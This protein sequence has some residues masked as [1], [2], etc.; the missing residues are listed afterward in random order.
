MT[1]DFPKPNASGTGPWVAWFGYDDGYTTISQPF[2][3]EHE[4][5]QDGRRISNLKYCKGL[6]FKVVDVSRC[7]HCG[8]PACDRYPKENNIEYSCGRS[9]ELEQEYGYGWRSYLDEGQLQC[10]VRKTL[11]DPETTDADCRAL[12][13][14]IVGRIM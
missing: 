6:P 8:S 14:R 11:N 9:Y 12:L 3:T 13:T 2:E 7:M 4:A 10:S 5:Q 1:Y